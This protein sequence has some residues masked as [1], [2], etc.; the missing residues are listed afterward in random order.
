M[1]AKTKFTKRLSDIQKDLLALRKAK[2][3]TDYLKRRP[4]E[5]VAK[6]L[7]LLK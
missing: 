2:K 3:E 5:N 6:E 1:S 4:Y 7:G